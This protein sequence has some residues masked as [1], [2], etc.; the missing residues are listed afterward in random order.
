MNTKDRLSEIFEWLKQEPK[1]IKPIDEI[2]VEKMELEIE[3]Q[4]QSVYDSIVEKLELELDAQEE[5]GIDFDKLPITDVVC[6]TSIDAEALNKLLEDWE[7]FQLPKFM[8]NWVF[9]Y[10]VLN[11]TSFDFVAYNYVAWAN[12]ELEK[13]IGA[14]IF[15]HGRSTFDGIRDLYFG[16]EASDNYGCMYYPNIPEYIFLLEALLKLEKLYVQSDKDSQQP[17]YEQYREEQLILQLAEI[18]PDEE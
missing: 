12:T 10:K 5:M 13:P 1:I 9:R 8:D 14:E 17:I 18:K 11:E 4:V 7:Y 16:S 15:L 6:N 2:D 3:E